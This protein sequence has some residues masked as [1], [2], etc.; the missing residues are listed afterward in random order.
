MA[1]PKI[2]FNSL[3]SLFSGNSEDLFIEYDDEMDGLCIFMHH[4]DRPVACYDLNDSVA[5]LADDRNQVVG[6]KLAHFVSKCLNTPELQDFKVTWE[7]K[8]LAREFSRHRYVNGQQQLSQDGGELVRALFR[9]SG[10]VPRVV[11]KD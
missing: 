9:R 3:H 1:I 11:E 7:Q 10:R 5:L 8:D 6:F 4:P 2:Q